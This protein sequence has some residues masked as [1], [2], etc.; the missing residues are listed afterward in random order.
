VINNDPLAGRTGNFVAQS[1]GSILTDFPFLGIGFALSDTFAQSAGIG[2][3]DSQI[4]YD[5]YFYGLVGMFVKMVF[6]VGVFAQSSKT[7]SELIL[8]MIMISNLY[9]IGLGLPVFGQ[10]RIGDF[11][12]IFIGYRWTQSMLRIA[13]QSN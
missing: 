9:A 12:W 2:L 8:M 10:E 4:Y 3:W 1:I 13:T 11:L 6:F 7:K 5:L